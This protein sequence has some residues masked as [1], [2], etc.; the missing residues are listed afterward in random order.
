MKRIWPRLW[1]M[2]RD[3]VPMSA[4][5]LGIGLLLFLGVQLAWRGAVE[6]RALD[7]AVTDNVVWTVS[8]AEV[9]FLELQ[10]VAL[11][12]GQGQVGADEMRRA[13]DVFYSRMET[14][15]S[16]PLYRDFA[17][18]AQVTDRLDALGRQIDAL[19]PVVD[20]PDAGLVAATDT[21]LARLAGMDTPLREVSTRMVQQ[22][23]MIQQ[24]ARRGLFSVMR[25]L[26]IVVVLLMVFM[27]ALMLI[28]GRLFLFA[29]S[30]ARAL[31]Q[32]SARLSTIVTTSQ[33]AIVVTDGADRITEFNAAAE[34]LFAVPRAD[35]LGAPIA[36]LAD[37]AALDGAARQRVEGR[38]QDGRRVTL[39]ATR[40]SVRADEGCVRVFVFRDISDRLAIEE[41]LRQSRDRARAGE[42]AKARFMAVMSHEMRTPLN[43]ILGVIDLLRDQVRGKDGEGRLRDYLDILQ[44]S[45]ETLLGHVN[46]V[47]DFTE[48]ESSGVRLTVEPVDLEALSHTI[49][50]GFEPVAR[51][52]GLRL[53]RVVHL[54]GSPMVLADPVRLRQVLT[55]LL[56]NAIKHT[57]TGHVTLEISGAGPAAAPI[58]EIQVSDTGLGIPAEAQERIFDDFVR[59]DPADGIERQGTGLGL[60]ITRR[61]VDAM[62][63]E[64]GVESEPGEGSLFW[65]RLPLRA[66]PPADADGVERAAAAV[67]GAG[68]AP[69]TQALRVLVVEDNPVNRFLL[70]EM[71][72]KDGHIVECAENG[73]A[74]LKAAQAR[75]FD[76]IVMDIAMPVMPGDAVVRAIR[77]GGGPNADSRIVAL[78]AHVHAADNPDVRA[79][80][81]DQVVTKPLTWQ[82]LRALVSGEA[83]PLAGAGGRGAEK[84][85]LLD[86]AT[87]ATLRRT[88]AAPQFEA[89][90]TAFRQ[91]GA[92]LLARPGPGATG[93]SDAMRRRV[94]DLA[95]MA[96]VLGARR[97]QI[98]LSEVETALLSGGQ[99]Q[100]QSTLA[101]LWFDTLAQLDAQAAP[102]QPA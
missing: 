98:H 92:A 8:Q 15:R 32:A 101:R 44:G 38:R 73:G 85:A 14:L 86:A 75:A 47:L 82:G 69:Q 18:A 100:P 78:T 33:D 58:V 50:R 99:M 54:P 62:G 64:I 4:L 3:W 40:G 28:L 60:G 10:R 17:E 16:A 61:L 41:D 7:N 12:A 102:A 42:R 9:E 94:H 91:E 20:G 63:G 88:L 77:A 56:D 46:D 48:L 76:L 93:D 2:R 65:V 49:M 45:G 68:A 90:L 39:E 34:S 79:A 70:R 51:G 80:G 22:V 95:G 23:A 53:E 43:G 52:R 21:V 29:R 74:G 57:E 5:A 26:A 35:V 83:A 55:N 1:R 66:L 25:N 87:F 97:L 6:L 37:V 24:A 30:R 96:A 72:E 81:F 84:A 19:L 89:L 67:A 36:R 13:F 31:R 11:L 71:L 59:L 27:A